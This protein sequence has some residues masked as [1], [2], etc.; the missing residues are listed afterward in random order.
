[1]TFNVNLSNICH[2]YQLYFMK[3][4]VYFVRW[5]ACSPFCVQS[6]QSSQIWCGRSLSHKPLPTL[7][8]IALL[9]IRTQEHST[10]QT[11]RPIDH[12]DRK[13]V[14]ELIHSVQDSLSWQISLLF[15]S[16][17]L[18]T[19]DSGSGSSVTNHHILIIGHAT[20]I[21]RLG[22]WALLQRPLIN[23]ITTEFISDIQQG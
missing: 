22:H 23:K 13:L 1:M 6:G 9:Q 2:P 17:K 11:K 18:S 21:H 20:I 8:H 19:P 7:E 10:R 3:S 16:L 15:V 4:L 12:T 5:K 14:S